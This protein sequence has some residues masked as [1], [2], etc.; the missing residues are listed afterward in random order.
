MLERDP[1]GSPRLD[2][3]D[4]KGCNL[5]AI[6]A[7]GT[8]LAVSTRGVKPT[9]TPMPGVMP[10][11]SFSASPIDMTASIQLDGK[12]GD[13]VANWMLGFIQLKYI[14][15]NFARYRGASV[16]DGSTL[17]TRSHSTLCRDT[18]KRSTEVWYDS[19]FSG[20]A[21]GPSGT[22]KLAA[23]TILPVSG[24]LKVPAHL[25]DQPDRFWEATRPNR[26]AGNRVN[27]LHYVVS[28]V[29]FCTMLVARDPPG[30][31]HMLKHVYWNVIW[32]QLFKRQDEQVVLDRTLRLQQNV[33]HSVHD[34]NP[35]DPRFWGREYDLS[36]P[37]ANTISNEPQ[38]VTEARDWSQG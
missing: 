11:F 1:C 17:V 14:G 29:F 33:Q 18:D 35:H 3:Y 24:S 26:L 15:V 12:P 25:S 30:T 5:T 37:V 34:G 16:K 36:L 27:Y 31:F 21:I 38:V 6:N 23:K 22:N 10:G 20:G 2:H 28:E 32:E 8:T 7:R 4:A 19:L 13:S 9:I